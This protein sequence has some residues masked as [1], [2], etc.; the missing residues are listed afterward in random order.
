MEFN[1]EALLLDF[2]L[3]AFLMLI[4]QIIRG[5]ISF[6]QKT[7]IPAPVIAGFL[8]LFLGPQF[9]NALPFSAQSSSYAWLL[10]VIVYAGLFIGKKEKINFKKIIGQTGDSFCVN[11]GAEILGFGVSCFLGTIILKILFG[12]NIFEG[13]ALLQPAGFVGGH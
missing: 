2:C 7:Y 13:F 5:K 9:L 11:M 1:G 6:F 3:M 8:G 10:T 12:K 4:A